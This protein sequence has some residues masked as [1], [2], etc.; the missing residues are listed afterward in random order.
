MVQIK[1]IIKKQQKNQKRDSFKKLEKNIKKLLINYYK[2]DY[3]FQKIEEN[4]QASLDYIPYTIL[5]KTSIY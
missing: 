5:T 1:K 3:I 4:G 2:F